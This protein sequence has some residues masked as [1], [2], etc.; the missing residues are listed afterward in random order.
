MQLRIWLTVFGALLLVLLVGWFV[1]RLAREHWARVTATP[2]IGRMIEAGEYPNAA[3]LALQAHAILPNDPAIRNL[4]IRATGEVS[5]NSDPR[6]AEV[7]YRLYHGDAR[8]WTRM[9]KPR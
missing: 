3:A 2:E 1:R 9:E 8:A 4:W 5:I 7:F 6:D